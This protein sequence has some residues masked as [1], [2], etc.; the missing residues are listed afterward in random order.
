MHVG[1]SEN[2]LK[3]HLSEEEEKNYVTGPLFF[4]K[5]IVNLSIKHCSLGINSKNFITFTI[6][7]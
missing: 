2:R 3:T 5:K 6:I 7:N 1:L 4:L